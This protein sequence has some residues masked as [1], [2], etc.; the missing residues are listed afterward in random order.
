MFS[1]LANESATY[2]FFADP[3]W[4]DISFGVFICIGCSGIHRSLGAHLCKVK[5]VNLDE[6]TDQH[7]KVC[8]ASFYPKGVCGGGV[9]PNLPN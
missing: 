3:D 8:V 2:C 4:A 9:P 1:L 5:S 7:V 6:W